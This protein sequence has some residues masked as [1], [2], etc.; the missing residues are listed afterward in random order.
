[1][2]DAPT[3]L[4]M[5]EHLASLHLGAKVLDLGCGAGSFAYQDFP[6]L[7]IAALDVK[8]PPEASSW[9]AHVTFYQGAAE[10][11]PFPDGAFDLAIANFVFEHTSDLARVVVE[12]DRVL[13]PGG[14]LYLSV[15]NAKSFEDDLYRALF[16]GGGH[17]Q[18]FRLGAILRTVYTHTGL[19]L[20]AYSD[21]P[22]GFTFFE[23][24]EGLR[25][26]TL[27][28][29]DALQRSGHPEVSLRA[30]F[31]MSFRKIGGVGYRTVPRVC[32]YCGSGNFDRPAEQ[33]DG[34]A[35]QCRVCGRTTEI[36]PV[37]LG[38]LDRLEAE[39]KSLRSRFRARRLL[40]AVQR[41]LKARADDAF[42]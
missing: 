14:A 19:K 9:P 34:R 5:H 26:F 40:R 24:R 33:S 11:L 1:M 12:A 37:S 10:S 39:A 7:Q 3:T 2:T 6:T 41:F 27:G 28:L 22:A 35:W 42:C 13:A 25:Q 21:W 29:V 15:P 16:A 17:R 38:S 31:V 32:S 8:K 36:K 30:N 18:Q 20:M 4:F 23:D